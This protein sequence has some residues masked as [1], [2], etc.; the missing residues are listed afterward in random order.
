MWFLIGVITAL[1]LVALFVIGFFSGLGGKG[2][3][4]ATWFAEL[5]L[6]LFE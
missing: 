5:I 3:N 6:K 2:R 1:A 4:P